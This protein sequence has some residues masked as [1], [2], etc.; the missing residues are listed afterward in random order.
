VAQ[1]GASSGDVRAAQY[2]FVIDDSGSMKQT[3]PDRLAIFAVQSLVG[4]LDD[5]DE[6]SV[7]RLNAP[8]EGQPPP[9]IEPLE[10]NRAAITS[11]LGL[12]GRLA[13]YPG[14]NTRCRSALDATKGLLE[15]AHRPGVSQVLF[16]LTDGECTGDGEQPSVD[17]FLQGLRSQDENLFQ[18]YVLRFRG[19][20]ITPA[21]ETLARRTDGD[22][23]DVGGEDPTS[24][25]A[26]F[27]RALSRS[28]GYE[29]YLLTPRDALLAAHRGAERV[30]LL[31]VAPGSGPNLAIRL[32]DRNGAAPPAAGRSKADVHRYQNGRVFRYATL[33][34]RP[35][36]EPVT[37]GVEGGG[38]AWK[39]V[40]L[41]EYRL[42]VRLSLHQGPCET[43]GPPAT[44]VEVG[45]SVCVLTELINAKGQVVGGEVTGGEIS[46]AVRVR[47]PGTDGT[48]DS[49]LPATPLGS[50]LARFGLTRSNLTRGDHIFEPSV[51]L[52]FA[53]GGSARLR[54]PPQTLEVSSMTIEPDPARL[55]LGKTMVPG[56]TADTT[57]RFNGSFPE[58]KV[59]W[60]LRNRESI[61]A[62][63]SVALSGTP[64]GGEQKL[65]AG[66]AQN[67]ALRV[68]P[69]CGPRPLQQRVETA[70]RF[71]LQT[72]RGVRVFEIPLTFTLDYRIATPA[73]LKIAVRGGQAGEVAVPVLGNF[74]GDVRLRAILAEPG[75][76]E[77][78]WPEDRADL[79]LG[80]AGE[81]RKKVLR[82][83]GEPLRAHDFAVGAGAPPLRLRALPHRCCDGGA[84]ETKLGLVPASS[85]P[86]PPG[87]AP[88][89]PIVLPVRVEVQP[90]GA[91]ACYGV[92]ILWVLAALLALL[93][94]LYLYS[95]LRNS[96]FL[97][98]DA[99]AA[100]LQPLVWTGFGEAVE[101]KN[102]KNEVLRLVRTGL[103]L[104]GRVLNWLRANPF[105]FGLPGGRYQESAELLLQAHRDI[106]RSQIALTPERD[107]EKKLAA[108]PETFAGR[109]FATASGSITFLGVPDTGGRLSRLVQQNGYLPGDGDTRPRVVK[110][111]R[112]KLLKRLE[113]W[114]S[115]EENTAAGWQVG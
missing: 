34:Y 54:H 13:S 78:P 96:S 60:E 50:G 20:K 74:L 102:T 26:P 115:P 73:D 94:L 97:K 49:V 92:L 81:G 113:D 90:A 80:F 6:V 2:V 30:R 36:A 83:K 15:A 68:A 62:C 57:V 27:A 114:E 37:V 9:P 56:S 100:R 8:Q 86:L 11:L 47:Q 110:L 10:R 106:A 44:S 45:S 23:I 72:A 91:W 109:L 3:D 5:L 52:S 66:Q 70:V 32:R 24:I 107:L 28:Q 76:D 95:M 58:G 103:P 82:E 99:L 46:A 19:K 53:S 84:Y 67:L 108:E 65:V 4:M 98:T 25:L 7:V 51:T 42:R 89:D 93:L 112:A 48:T 29:S 17:G 22:V 77:M 63:V 85:Q 64:E 1:S 101:Q 35:G 39:V 18:L 31:A 12:D 87:A 104:G 59:R 40:A 88:L 75:E 71:S 111:R 14:E 41:P 43:L 38:V 33:D 79:T 105:R 21:L 16:F 61:P 69:Y 55:A